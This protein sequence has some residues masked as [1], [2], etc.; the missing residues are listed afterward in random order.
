MGRVVEVAALIHYRYLGRF[1]ILGFEACG[2]NLSYVRIRQQQ[3]Q[4]ST[5]AETMASA[6][7]PRDETAGAEG[8]QGNG[9][10]AVGANI[11]APADA[12]KRSPWK[13]WMY[14]WE[15][16]PSHYPA[17]ER[18]LLRKMDACL[19]TFCSFMCMHPFH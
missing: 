17:E 7:S 13:A 5:R 4:P 12:P 8:R 9:E 11:I 6:T 2:S 18:K 15:W 19:L 14:L 10:M 16:Y 1:F 3:S